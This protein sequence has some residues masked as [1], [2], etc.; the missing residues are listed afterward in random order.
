MSGAVLI[1]RDIPETL[2]IFALR[3]QRATERER[4][5]EREKLRMTKQLA[6]VLSDEKKSLTP[7][8][9][10]R[11]LLKFPRNSRERRAMKIFTRDNCSDYCKSERSSTCR[12]ERKFIRSRRARYEPV[13][14]PFLQL[15]TV[16]RSIFSAIFTLSLKDY[17]ELYV[18]PVC[19]KA[20]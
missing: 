2:Y 16:V 17:A 19:S 4:K 1:V 7:I 3:S 5:R 10:K 8:S 15:L 12:L 6:L 14:S 11:T 20:R 13:V 9:D 18:F